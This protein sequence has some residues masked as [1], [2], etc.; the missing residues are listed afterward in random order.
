MLRKKTTYFSI[1]IIA[2]FLATSL[3]FRSL[4]AEEGIIKEVT[5]QKKTTEST[6]SQSSKKNQPSISFDATTFDAG[7]VWEG[8]TVTHSFTVKNTGTGE[9]TIKSVKPG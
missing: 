1:L 9:L 2:C 5:V 6:Q 4:R 3:S 8:D 7:E